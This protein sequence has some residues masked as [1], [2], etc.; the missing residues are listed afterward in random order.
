MLEKF[1][2]NDI[3]LIIPSI[4]QKTNP[5]I[6]LFLGLLA[7]T[8]TT[9]TVLTVQ[10]GPAERGSALLAPQLCHSLLGFYSASNCL[11]DN[12]E[13]LGVM[14]AFLFSVG[15]LLK[16]GRANLLRAWAEHS[17]YPSLCLTS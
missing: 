11:L 9:G 17:W 1:P 14:Y 6:C 3:N 5:I 4:K 8:N 15:P 7:Q 13:E 2:P 10:M 12:I 16:S